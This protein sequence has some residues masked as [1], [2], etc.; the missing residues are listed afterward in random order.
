MLVFIDLSRCLTARYPRASD[1]TSPIFIVFSNLRGDVSEPYA[2]V[3]DLAA[4]QQPAGR[5]TQG[6]VVML[7]AEYALFQYVGFSG[8][9]IL[10][11]LSYRCTL[12]M[13]LLNSPSLLIFLTIHDELL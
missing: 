1:N 7:H 5:V 11:G 2:T 10:V 4:P 9:H 6:Y 3:A 8:A 12:T 13:S